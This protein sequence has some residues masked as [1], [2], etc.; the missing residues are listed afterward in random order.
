M[1]DP[2]LKE[3]ERAWRAARRLASPTQS[4]LQ[5]ANSVFAPASLGSIHRR[6]PA[7]GAGAG[8]PMATRKKT[9]SK[10]QETTLR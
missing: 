1:C 10:V 6:K 3:W 8:A 5:P 4:S 7:I 2:L 9:K